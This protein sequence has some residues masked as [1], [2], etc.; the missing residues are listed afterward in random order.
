VNDGPPRPMRRSV[1]V[2]TFAVQAA[3]ALLV[4][5]AVAFV[6]IYWRVTFLAQQS[7]IEQARGF[8]DLV[9][10]VRAWN[11]SHGGVWV[12][13][14]PTSQSNP[15]LRDLGVE[16]DTSTVSGNKLTLR[17][18]SAMTREISAIAEAREMITFRMTSLRPV[19]PASAPDA[20]ERAQLTRFESDRTE[21]PLFTKSNG[22]RVLRLMR[23]LIV[24]ASCLRCH[25]AQGYRVGDVRGA[26]SV[27]LPLT[28][29]DRAVAEDAW[30]LVGIFILVVIVAGLVG[31]LLVREMASRIV[32][33]EELLRTAATTDTLTGLANRRAV[34]ARLDDEFARAKRT[35]STMGVI[36]MDVDHFKRVNDSLGHAAGDTVLRELA[37]RL[38]GALRE[39]DVIGRVGGEEFLVVAS[40][41]Q[42]EGLA[43]L[44]ERLRCAVAAGPVEHKSV[45][46]PVTI[47]AGS[48]LAREGDTPD[49]LI[50]RADDALYKAKANGRSCVQAG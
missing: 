14:S 12:L 29:S 22:V 44:G 21:I 11:A 2:R 26:I 41:I 25:G 9:V 16:P 18:P 17:N 15:Y 20:W 38:V 32:E 43:E 5:T 4:F 35:G 30:T 3:V 37:Q 42:D 6:G 27:S 49:S 34:L 1:P 33:S 31:Y 8:V 23:P 48:A 19:N 47:S 39:Y 45:P 40:D 13:K 36:M 10:D 28:A 7:M 46:I 50:A 24:D